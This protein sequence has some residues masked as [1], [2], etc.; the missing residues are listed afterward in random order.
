MKYTWDDV[1]K[2]LK[3]RGVALPADDSQLLGV[4]LLNLGLLD[5]DMA[6]WVR[7]QRVTPG[8][9][10]TDTDMPTYGD[11]RAETD[12]LPQFPDDGIKR[13]DYK[14]I[15]PGVAS[16][17]VGDPPPAAGPD[18]SKEPRPLPPGWTP[19]PPMEYKRN[20]QLTPDEFKALPRER[21]MQLLNN[22]PGQGGNYDPTSDTQAG[23]FHPSGEWVPF[24]YSGYAGLLNEMGRKTNYA[25][26]YGQQAADTFSQGYLGSLETAEGPEA[27]YVRA[28]LKSALENPAMYQTP[29]QA[30]GG[31]TDPVS[32]LQ[33]A[34]QREAE[35]RD[36]KAQRRE[37]RAEKQAAKDT[38]P[39]MAEGT[40]GLEAIM[41]MLERILAAVGEEE[42]PEMEEGY[43]EGEMPEF[44]AECG[45]PKKKGVMVM[46][47]KKPEM[48]EE[49]E[50][51]DEEEGLPR[52]ATGTIG[53]SESEGMPVWKPAKAEEAPTASWLKP[54]A[55]P[56]AVAAQPAQ[57][58]V[59]VNVNTQPQ[60]QQ[61]RA[62][63]GPPII[64]GRPGE[65]EPAPNGDPN[66][67]RPQP[68]PQPQPD[69]NP[70]PDPQPNPNP[71]PEGG[72]D[73][74]G[75]NEEDKPNP[76]MPTLA[77][78]V[79]LRKMTDAT[80]LHDFIRQFF[81]G[82][83][84]F[85][86]AKLLA[87]R[88]AIALLMTEMLAGAKTYDEV[89]AQLLAYQQDDAAPNP[90]TPPADDQPPAE[91]DPPVDGEDPPAD[92]DPAGEEPP[93]AFNATDIAYVNQLAQSQLPSWTQLA[94]SYLG[95]KGVDFTGITDDELRANIQAAYGL[96]RS[97]G[98]AVSAAD[99]AKALNGEPATP[100]NT[101]AANDSAKG[102]DT[103][104]AQ[105]SAA[106]DKDLRGATS[107]VAGDD[108]SGAD[109][110]TIQLGNGFVLDK[111]RGV[112]IDTATGKEY[113]APGT[114]ISD[115]NAPTNIIYGPDAWAKNP[116][117]NMLLGILGMPA[118]G[119][120]GN[121]PSYDPLYKT[122]ILG[123]N[124]LN[125]N[126]MV[127]AL[128]DPTSAAILDAAFKRH[129]RDVTADTLAAGRFAPLGDAR[130]PSSIRTG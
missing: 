21:Q 30:L 1:R 59:T 96:M 115:S 71:A 50:D 34:Y 66:R 53:V 56:Q 116:T 77:D 41:P 15:V 3:E 107:S 108:T 93:A 78:I 55:Q 36:R 105:P 94:R 68:N 124:A 69:P 81:P 45:G 4:S 12:G 20:P 97:T 89:S 7:D 86:G 5:G 117:L 111:V 103:P 98:G 80:E 51:D 29:N 102:S 18:Y 61:S 57:P 90:D 75:P 88:D 129:N 62:F 76:V 128:S 82:Q 19:P 35:I 72:E 43:E 31:P 123:T 32:Q 40:V 109:Q 52:F 25:D 74:P 13:G 60:Q 104:P 26:K 28:N 10:S 130:L 23:Y 54:K 24:D 119:K 112:I 11:E 127:T 65:A 120:L 126:D 37:A 14:V 73:G 121:M 44:D 83:V 63:N 87:G 49:Y 48:D 100:V 38:A 95:S 125:Y 70:Q 101:S 99:I 58:P 47:S 9:K 33:A 16:D 118:Y 27:D 39:L 79:A 92:D 8:K 91:G 17:G 122:R 113:S 110:N 42:M 114:G 64:F 84:A 46:I 67:P 2:A 85:D 106:P 6:T 22:W